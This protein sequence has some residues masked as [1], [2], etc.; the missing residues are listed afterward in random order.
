MTEGQL[1]FLLLIFLGVLV[2]IGIVESALGSHEDGRRHHGSAAN[3]SVPR[4]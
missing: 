3:K 2:I 1:L 4:R